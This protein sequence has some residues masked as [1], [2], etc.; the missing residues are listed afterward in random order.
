MALKN[1]QYYA[2]M[3]DYEQKRLKNHDIQTARYEEVYKKL[4]EFRTLDES[5]S[6]LSVQYG[7]KLLD[8]D[9]HAL[10]SLREELEI[11]RSSKKNLLTSAGFP[12]DYLA[13][14]AASPRLAELAA[15]SGV[16][17]PVYAEC[18]GFM[19]LSRS[20]TQNGK[21]SSAAGVL[22]VDIEMHKRPV[23]LG[24]VT[25]ETIRN[26]PFYPAGL[27]IRG[28]E[29]HFSNVLPTSDISAPCLRLS[30]GRGFGKG[31]D[32]ITA[33]NTWGSYTHIFAPILPEWAGGLVRL[34]RTW[35][36]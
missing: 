12:E 25:G 13:E 24:Y 1:S 19:V 17:L 27:R 23:G 26:T 5:I 6:I 8:G 32:A 4:P 11:L 29:F 21:R 7:K 2:I 35:R 3:R 14:L 9:E 16:G 22:P 36:G 28:H 18:G 20:I 15:A 33:G 31:T 34:A 30:K 10:D